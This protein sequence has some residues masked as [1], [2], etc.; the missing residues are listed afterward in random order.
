MF[1]DF[2]LSETEIIQFLSEINAKLQEVMT[3]KDCFLQ[4]KGNIDNEDFE[5]VWRNASNV[6]NLQKYKLDEK[7]IYLLI[8]I[9]IMVINSLES[10]DGENMWIYKYSI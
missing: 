6:L 10:Y 5:F 2:E 4:T 3:Q 9:M 8:Y 7:K 1:P